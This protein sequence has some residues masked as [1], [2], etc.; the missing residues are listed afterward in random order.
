MAHDRGR[1][2]LLSVL[3]HATAVLHNGAGRYETALRAARRAARYDDPG[4]HAFVPS[5]VV[6]AAV[7]AG[8]PELAEPVMERLVE[9]TLVAGTDWAAGIGLR[10]RA[11]LTGGP[12]AEDL[13]REAI[14]RLAR[15][16]AVPQLARTR[17][18]YGEWLRRASRRGDARASSAAHTRRS[19]RSARPGSAARRRP[20]SSPPAATVPPGRARRRWSGSPRRRRASRGSS[21]TARRRRRPPGGCSSARAPWTRTCAASS[22]S[23]A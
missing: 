13:Y 5:E 20:P 21:P 14:H 22:G 23:W 1:G 3:D 15:T 4:L 12:R 16:R 11:L 10:S 6:E 8:R 19:P 2:Q 18:L 17:L 7:R 9:R